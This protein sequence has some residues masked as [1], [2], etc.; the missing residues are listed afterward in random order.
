MVAC[1]CG[2]LRCVLPLQVHRITDNAAVC[3]HTQAAPPHPGR[4][5][6]AT[7][8]RTQPG[9]QATA[10]RPGVCCEQVGSTPRPKVMAACGCG[11]LRCVLPPQ[12]HRITDIAAVCIH[13]QAAPLNTTRPRTQPGMR[14]AAP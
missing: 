7:R 8:R 3:I 13:M 14:P 5:L 4:P 10:P 11:A 2:A 1:G 12:V 9:T 6:R